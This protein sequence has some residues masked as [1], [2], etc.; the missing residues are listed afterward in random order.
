MKP[1][2]LDPH[3][4]LARRAGPVGLAAIAFVVAVVQG[5]GAA[6]TPIMQVAHLGL[7]AAGNREWLVTVAPDP[8]LF[9]S[10]PPANG[11]SLAVELGLEVVQGELAS[12][13]G[14]AE[15]WPYASP[16]NN[17]FTGS[18]SAGLWIDLPGGKIFSSLT[19]KFLTDD[20]PV[21]LLRFQTAGE[22]AAEVSWGGQ[23]LLAGAA[24]Q[25]TGARIAQEGVNYD[26]YQGA[27]AAPAASGDFDGDSIVDGYDFLLWQ[28]GL[29]LAGDAGLADGDADG[30]RVVDA[31]DLSVW[32]GRFGVAPGASTATTPE[33][34]S[35]ALCIEL[36]LGAWHFGRMSRRHRVARA[37]AAGSAS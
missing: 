36:L 6:A 31:I 7:N 34:G 3:L 4:A 12:A 37:R 11:S 17:P 20:T 8:A 33:P 5:L 29:G 25:Y 18:A 14:G 21:E 23:V 32:R 9:G 10:M 27:V 13:A 28:R 24:F 1:M 30:D 19:S 35:G 16:G 15:A 22:G 26:G 2:P